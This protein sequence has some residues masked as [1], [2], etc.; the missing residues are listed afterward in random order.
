MVRKSWLNTVVVALTAF[1]AVLTLASQAAEVQVKPFTITGEGVAP[2]GLPLPGQGARP[3]SIAGNATHLGLHTG[4]G[5]VQT[6]SASFNADGTI[7]GEFGSGSPFIF[8][9]ANGDKLVCDYGRTDSG[10]SEPGTFELTILD[11]LDDGSLVVEALFIAEFVPQPDQ[12]TGKFAGVTGSWI[13]YAWTE[14]FVLG[15]SDPIAYSWEGN[16]SLTFKK[17][18]S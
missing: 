1:V 14:P 17:G 7:T 8:T 16:G 9:G 13:M 2:S 10:A 5:T 3:H 4:E 11:V 15:S 12:S 6:D 18:K